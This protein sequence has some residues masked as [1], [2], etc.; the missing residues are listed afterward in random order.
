MRTDE[1]AR[2]W[3]ERGADGLAKILMKHWDPIGVADSSEAEGEYETYV[4]HVGQ[5]LRPQAPADEIADY[6][7][8]IR[9]QRMELPASP[10]ADAEAAEAICNWYA[11]EVDW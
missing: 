7:T 2:W 10:H 8:T 6:L 5:L 1:W 3:R 9:T 11:A 4:P